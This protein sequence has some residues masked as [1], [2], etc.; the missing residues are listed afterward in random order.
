[1]VNGCHGKEKP[2]QTTNTMDKFQS[3]DAVAPSYN[4][5]FFFST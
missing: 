2:G 3:Q 5:G 1:M 4:K